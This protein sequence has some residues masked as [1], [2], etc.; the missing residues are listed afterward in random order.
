MCIVSLHT[1]WTCVTGVRR[2]KLRDSD[3]QRTGHTKYDVANFAMKASSAETN[4][5]VQYVIHNY[6]RNVHTP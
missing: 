6:F 4:G 5:I 1:L 2:L 3:L